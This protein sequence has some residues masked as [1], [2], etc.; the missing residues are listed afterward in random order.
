[1]HP[2][3]LCAPLPAVVN[4]DIGIAVMAWSDRYL[5]VCTGQVI[6]LGPD[7]TV[8]ASLFTLDKETLDH[9]AKS[10][11]QVKIHPVVGYSRIVDTTDRK[12]INHS[13]L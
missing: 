3:D 10:V 11:N 9:G 12:V 7:L 5:T 2:V 6:R 13:G 1:M 4:A 8:N